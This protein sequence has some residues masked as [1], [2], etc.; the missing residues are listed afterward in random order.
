MTTP[1]ILIS[2]AD[3]QRRVREL[4]AEISN[5]YAGEPVTLVG[6]L[7]GAFIFLADLSRHLT[8]PRSIEFMAVSSYGMGTT[9]SGAVR[10][11]MDLRRSIEGRHVLVVEDIVDTGLTLHYLLELLSTRD[12]ASLKTCALVRKKERHEVD[13]KVDYLGFDIPNVW[14]V[15]YGLDHAE[16][17]R[18]LPYIGVV[19]PDD[20][21]AGE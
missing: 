12:P 13:V 3:I 20:E 2:E 18:A 8:M 9:S 4:A 11:L 1:R 17:L 19:D 16:D 10:V 5:D 14:V 15:G 6:V 21:T 7:K